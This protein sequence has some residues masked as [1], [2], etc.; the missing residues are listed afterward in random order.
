[1]KPMKSFLLNAPLLGA[2][3]AVIAAVCA[4]TI[5]DQPPAGAPRIP[6]GPEIDARPADAS[7]Q[8]GDRTLKEKIKQL[9]PSWGIPAAEIDQVLDACQDNGC[10]TG[11]RVAL[12]LAIRKAENGGPGIEYGIV[13]RRGSS[14][15][16]QAGWCAATVAKFLGDEPVTRD[17]VVSLSRKYCPNNSEVWARNVLYWLN[18]ICSDLAD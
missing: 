3:A 7:V 14:Y 6:A 16:V 15:R 1:M 5:S 8:P 4:L 18:R 2:T 13:R 10:S 12:V 11:D 17:A 9:S